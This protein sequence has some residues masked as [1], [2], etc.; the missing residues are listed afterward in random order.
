[1]RSVVTEVAE[2]HS[3]LLSSAAER[4]QADLSMPMR[5]QPRVP[6]RLPGCHGRPCPPVEV[7]LPGPALQELYAISS[8]IPGGIAGPDT[9]W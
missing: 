9:L 2:V 6:R 8:D 4:A 7:V 3:S 1:M 5:C